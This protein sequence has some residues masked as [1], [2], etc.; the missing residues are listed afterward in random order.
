MEKHNMWNSLNKVWNSRPFKKV[1]AYGPKPENR[2][3]RKQHRPY[4]WTKCRAPTWLTLNRQTRKTSVKKESYEKMC[5][6]VCRF[7]GDPDFGSGGF[8]IRTSV[9]TN[10]R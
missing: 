2:L 1:P 5:H 4:K 6:I 8:A 3:Y 9:Y 10:P 7:C